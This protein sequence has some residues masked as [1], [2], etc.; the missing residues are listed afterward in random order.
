[1]TLKKQ[2]LIP[3]KDHVM[4]YVP[5]SRLRKD[6]ND[7]VIGILG[8]AFALRCDEEGLSVTWLEYFLGAQNDQIIQAVHKNRKCLVAMPKSGF[9]IGKVSD[10]SSECN[11]RN[12]H[13]KIRIVYMPTSCNKAHAEVRSLPRDDAELLDLL[14]ADIWAKLILNKD[15]PP[16]VSG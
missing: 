6:E 8:E 4:R 7:N 9:A 1:M 11:K 16:V 12:R 5:W 3:D 14:A 15:I 13:K 2:E 10:I